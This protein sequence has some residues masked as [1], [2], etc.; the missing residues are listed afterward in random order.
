M[1]AVLTYLRSYKFSF[2]MA[3]VLMLVELAVELSQ[4]FLMGVIIDQGILQKDMSAVATWGGLLLGLSLVAFAAGIASSF[5]AANVSQGVGHDLRRDMYE[6]IQAFSPIHF[7]SFPTSSLITRLT[8]DV[9]QVQGFLFMGMRIMLRAPLFII[10]GMIMAFV[11]HAQ[12]AGILL[13]AVPF[14][15][16]L[17]FWIMTK[18]VRLFQKVQKRLDGVNRVIRENL[19]NMRLVKAY[20]RGEYERQGFLNVNI[21]LMKSNKTALRLMETTMPI[22]M[23]GMNVALVALLWFGALELRTNG[24]QEGELVSVLNY[25]TR[26]MFSFSVFTFLIMMFSR[27]RASATRITEVLHQEST[28]EVWKDTSPQKDISGSITFES[29]S[30]S[31]PSSQVPALHDVSF[32]IGAGE[33]VGILGET[34]SGKS[35]LTQLIPR[36]YEPTSGTIYID[37]QDSSEINIKALRKQVGFVPQE[38]HLFTGTIRENIA[39]GKDDATNEEI[40]RAAEEANIH[41][42]IES[43]A[44]GYDTQ[45]GQKGVNLSGGQKQRLSI[46]RALVK[47]PSVLVLDDSTSALDANTEADILRTL[48]EL[49]CTVFIIA[50]KISSVKEADH[51]I[52]LRQ[53]SIVDQGNHNALL[54]NSKMYQRIYESQVQKGVV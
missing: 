30:F 33:M 35:S 34:G 44:E 39:W 36:L 42:F 32:N 16:I 47:K 26:M 9:T 6:K 2:V 14:L 46:A 45:I 48:Q 3:I 8:N 49:K 53:G 40:Q 19:V 22:V 11:V 31:Y 37:G 7:Q 21:P 23:F 20:D 27:G 15:F 5:F 12:L 52:V 25:G 13:M 43:L 50:Q 18:G 4:P 17:M 51:I 29:V 10:G 41:R 28:S 24:A 38:A 1:K 54:Q